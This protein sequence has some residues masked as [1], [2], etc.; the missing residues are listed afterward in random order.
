METQGE[1][2]QRDGQ[3]REEEDES[4]ERDRGAGERVGK[5]RGSTREESV[6]SLHAEERVSGGEPPNTLEG[7]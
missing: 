1:E 3:L 4:N 5:R 6:G 7:P 2:R